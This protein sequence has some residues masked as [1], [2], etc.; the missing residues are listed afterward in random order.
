[1][2]SSLKYVENKKKVAVILSVY[3]GNKYI[4]EQ[5]N[6]ILNQEYNTDEYQL[7][8][9]IRDDS[10]CKDEKM[11]TYF[12]SLKKNPYVEII[13][14]EIENVGV[15]KSFYELLKYARSDYYFFSD[16]DDIWEKN[17]VSIFLEQFKLIDSETPALIYSDLLLID[18]NNKSMGSTMKETV[19]KNR[20]CNSFFNR[21]LD[22][23]ITGASMAI[24]RAL[25]DT[26]IDEVN[27]FNSIV[28]HDSYLGI[29]ASLTGNI[30]FIDQAL[31]RYRQHS[32]NVVGIKV[33]KYSRLN[34]FKYIE[35]YQW[36]NEHYKQAILAMYYIRKH[37]QYVKPENQN[38]L[39]ALNELNSLQRFSYK[40]YSQ[41]IRNA[42][43]VTDKI[44]VSYQW[45]VGIR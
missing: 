15:Q 5:V 1:M 10:M 35:R 3:L 13:N 8:L 23:S 6:S 26:V 2:D 27:Y 16:Q 37:G 30:V 19:G 24:N 25:R 41:L 43:G 39:N 45:L 14:R 40:N 12:E 33:K 38:L 31:T 34:P 20:D 4:S 21:L 22:D 18:E 32:N 17:K 11:Y 7:T 44:I 42:K 28:M 9:Y 29:V 36:V